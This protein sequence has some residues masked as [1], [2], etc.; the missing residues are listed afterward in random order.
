MPTMVAR[1]YFTFIVL[2]TA[3]LFT[4]LSSLALTGK[5]SKCSYRHCH[6]RDYS[7]KLSLRHC[8]DD[9]V[10]ASAVLNGNHFF[11]VTHPQMVPL[12]K[13]PLLLL[14]SSTPIISREGSSL[15]SR[16]FDQQTIVDKNDSAYRLDE[17]KIQSAEKL[18]CVVHDVINKVTNCPKHDGEIC[19]G[20]APSHSAL[21]HHEVN[22]DCQG[23]GWRRVAP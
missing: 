18:L 22:N 10:S 9:N 8:S 13:T 12:S 16:Y 23:L 2:L 14:Q 4:S 1:S 15:L 3:H 6:R 11:L 19:P 7:Q 20:Q 21:S 17:V 5:L